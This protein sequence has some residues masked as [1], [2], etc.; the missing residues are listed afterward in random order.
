LREI[1]SFFEG[2]Q[3]G[4]YPSAL[5]V[6]ELQREYLG[7]QDTL[8]HFADE[9]DRVVADKGGDG[10]FRDI[11]AEMRQGAKWH[12]GL[13]AEFREAM[14]QLLGKA[15][16]SGSSS[17][18]KVDDPPDRRLLAQRVAAAKC[19]ISQEAERALRRDQEN[20]R[21]EDLLRTDSQQ[22]AERQYE[23][24]EKWKERATKDRDV[25]ADSLK[26][27][28]RTA[29]IVAGEWRDSALWA[30]RVFVQRDMESEHPVM[31]TVDL[32]GPGGM[33]PKETLVMYEPQRW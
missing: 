26:S 25:Y 11:V 32:R 31:T 6:A 21:R 28:L 8:D 10:A 23:R 9:I 17:K 15:D 27:Q 14:V 22:E 7:V 3:P 12:G 20:R 13:L 30:F 1:A 24:A 4:E 33:G 29:V 2:Q 18:K 16:F 5:H 19:K